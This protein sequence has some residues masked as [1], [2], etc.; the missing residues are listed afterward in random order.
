MYRGE[1]NM[2]EKEN[3]NIQKYDKALL[4]DQAACE[5]ARHVKIKKTPIFFK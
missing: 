2:K 5:E 1:I 3:K 4:R